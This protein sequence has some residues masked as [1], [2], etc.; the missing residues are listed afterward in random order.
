[1]PRPRLFISRDA[2]YDWLIALEFGVTDD[3]Q[4]EE[5]WRPVSEGL[6][7]LY[8]APEG[9]RCLGFVVQHFSEFDPQADEVDEI[10]RGPRFDVP[11]LGLTSASAG[12]IVVATEAFLGEQST[13]NRYFFD[14]AVAAS[15]RPRKAVERW[16]YCLQTGDVM[17][18]YGLGYTLYELGCHHEAYRH[19]R[20]YTEIAPTNTW[21]WCWFGKAAEALGE[22]DEAIAA[23]NRAVELEEGGGDETDAADL[24]DDLVDRIE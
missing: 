1:M 10:W 17:A 13:V 20:A 16:R 24:L 11:T 15:R 22:T 23:Y 5:L 6:R 3:G 9:G 21:A 14:Q 2:D 4:P 8:D 18:H 7:Y 19:L 12:E